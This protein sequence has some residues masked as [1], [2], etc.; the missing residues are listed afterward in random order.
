M[1]LDQESLVHDQI[2]ISCDGHE[3]NRIHLTVALVS[4]SSINNNSN[5]DVK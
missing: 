4:N 3:P 1:N 2:C 5:N